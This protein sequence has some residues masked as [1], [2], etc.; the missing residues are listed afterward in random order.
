M[1]EHVVPTVVVDAYRVRPGLSAPRHNWKDEYIK[2]TTD[3]ARQHG[4]AG[5]LQRHQQS[6]ERDHKHKG[7]HTVYGWLKYFKKKKVIIFTPK[8]EVAKG[9]CLR[10]SV[11]K[12]KMPSPN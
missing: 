1:D 6:D 12:F 7:Y 10:L 8:N 5:A 2:T 4:V 9:F 3:W 11:Q